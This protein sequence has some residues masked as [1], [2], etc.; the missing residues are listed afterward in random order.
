MTRPHLPAPVAALVVILALVAAACSGSDLPPETSAADAPLRSPTTVV[1][2]PPVLER[3]ALEPTLFAGEEDQRMVAVA[4]GPVVG[5]G[6]HL[7]AV[8][9]DGG[10][11]SVWWSA[12]GITW[13]RPAL[14]PEV[15]GDDAVLADVVADPV[16]GGFVAVGG[17]GEAAAAW[18]S[19]DGETWMATQ[20]EPGPAMNVVSS[21]HLGLIAFGTGA[22]GGAVGEDLAEETAAWQSFSGE[23]WLRAVDDPDLFARRGS[24]AVV[25]VVDAGR[26][27]QALVERG[28]QGAELWRT[29]DGLFWSAVPDVGAGLL[30]AEGEPAPAAATALGS[31]LVVVGTDTKA[32][33]VDASL[34][35]STGTRDFEQVAHD[36][37][38]LGG[39]GTQAM[40]ALVQV[41]DRLITVG[42]DTAD[43]GDVDAVVWSSG[44]GLRVQRAGVHRPAVPGDQHVV[45]I[46]VLGSTPVAVGWEETGSGVDAVVWVVGGAPAQDD[47]EPTETT[48]DLGWQRVMDQD[49]LNG[50]GEQ[51]LEAIAARPDGFLAVGSAPAPGGDVDGAVW[52]SVDGQDWSVGDAGSF[53]GPGPQQLLDVATT[54]DASVVV[55]ADG[56]SAAIWTSPDGFAWTRVPHDEAVFGGPG[57]QR[58]EAVT[59]LPDGRGWLGVG[60]G[61]QGDAAAWASSD[62]STWVRIA[63]EGLDGPAD[64][65]LL[66]VVAGQGGLV[67]VGT[68]GG[69][70]A[71]WVSPDGTAWSRTE[72]GPG[73]ATA[74]TVG[75]TGLVAVGSTGGDGLDAASW[76]SADGTTWTR[77][78]G[79]EL[80]G[81]SDQQLAGVTT[82]DEVV[83]A[84]GG[85]DLGGGR[86]A[87]AWI[88]SS[89]G[90]WSRSAHHE[91]VFGG[92]QAQHMADVASVGNLVV[93][94]GWSG[95]SPESRDAAV[96]TTDVAGGRARSPL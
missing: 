6:A 16:S 30:P 27:V 8:G 78:E 48:P 23:R 53:A 42:T 24:E 28:G 7:V 96:W 55:G 71:A 86:D 10:R 22:P 50:P 2:P 72:L 36:E 76:H 60:S 56:A 31:A 35:L 67:A 3:V 61:G 5:A 62:G 47:L 45:D 91:N 90:T 74:L 41:G 26:E 9:S 1:P 80:T 82:S 77:S 64:Q 4:A 75:E 33:G 59:T 66:D 43:D 70:A 14:A 93:A 37:E 63:A 54:T 17:K 49:V 57:D 83:V 46:A 13:R 39:D 18:R 40:E 68:D 85:T 94:V 44:L 79:E 21:T 12:D 11:P 65:S 84:V 29:T 87:A 95:S 52:R 34:W 51:R 32:D 92:D 20:V 88:S 69:S 81:P 25:A 89:A 73:R 19:P 38:L 15:F 58:V